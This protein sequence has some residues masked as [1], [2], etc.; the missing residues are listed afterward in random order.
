M[1]LLEN[2]VF[3]IYFIYFN[4]KMFWNML[5]WLYL[6]V[7]NKKKLYTKFSFKAFCILVNCFS[8][9]FEMELLATI[10]RKNLLFL[11]QYDFLNIWFDSTLIFFTILHLFASDANLVLV[12][13]FSDVQI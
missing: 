5:F 8:G 13:W 4:Q 2:L 12:D 6:L 3:S 9:S 11:L 7:G 10:H 1:H